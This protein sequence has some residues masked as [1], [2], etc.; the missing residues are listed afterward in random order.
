MRDSTGRLEQ[1]EALARL[2]SVDSSARRL[3]RDACV[4]L[5][6]VMAEQRQPEAALAGERAVA[7]AAVAAGARED[8][9]HLG[10]ETGAGRVEG[11]AAAKAG[12]AASRNA[13]EAARRRME[14]DPVARRVG[15][16]VGDYL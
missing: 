7:R 5:V 4:V 16:H 10:G 15:G 14:G 8:G 12:V 3:A 9:R 11:G 13:R 2:E 1:Q 6:G